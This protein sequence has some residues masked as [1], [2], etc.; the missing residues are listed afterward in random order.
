MQRLFKFIKKIIILF[1]IISILLVLMFRFINPPGTMLMVE[2]KLSNW[3]AKQDRVWRDFDAISDNIKIAVIAAEDQNFI[4]HFGFD[5]DAIER[6]I[7]YNENNQTV[8]GAST[9]TQQVAKNLFLWPSRNFIRKGFEL[10]FTLWIELFWSKE[11]ILEVYL[12]SVEWGE[13]IFGIDAAAQYYFKTSA[14]KLTLEQ[15]SLLAA[16]LPNP[17]YLSPI[18]PNQYVINKAKWIQEQVRNLDKTRYLNKIS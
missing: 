15:A 4:H 3:S 11:R 1:V 10:W 14:K 12:N 16:I 2:Q 8:R 13:G 9:I 17:R 18:H 6:A 5:V 7:T